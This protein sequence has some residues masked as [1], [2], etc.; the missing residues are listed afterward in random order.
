MSITGKPP[1]LR[2]TPDAR[3]QRKWSIGLGIA[4][5]LAIVAVSLC[6]LTLGLIVALGHAPAQVAVPDVQG[7]TLDQ[8]Q[9]ALKQRGLEGK[10]RYALSD[11]VPAGS[12]VSQRPYVGK[13]VRVGRMVDLLVSN[14][15][16]SVAVPDLVGKSLS[17]SQDLLRQSYLQP[18]EIKRQ[19]SDKPPDTVLEQRP[20]ASTIV[21]RDKTVDLQ[22]SGGPD[23]GIW[24]DTQGQEWV[25]QKLTIVV[26]A[27]PS[28]QRVRVALETDGEDQN[29]YDEM[30]RPGDTV[31][32][33]VRGKRGAKVKVYVEE[34]R[35]FSQT[36]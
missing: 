3:R 14:G 15:P 23:F 12:V 33:D 18:G 9:Q 31:A 30:H 25:F 24:K 4:S 36:L 8:A 22:V 10:A 29:L 2:L 16:K 7:Q 26:P 20:A 13:L 21:D 17:E 27:G 11:S 1:R 28:L 35:I 34:R 5:S 19:A 6:A 32:L